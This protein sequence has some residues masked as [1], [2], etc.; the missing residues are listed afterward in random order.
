MQKKP[1]WLQK[2]LPSPSTTLSGLHNQLL[3]IPGPDLAPGQKS[4]VVAV[5][6][7][8]VQFF[9]G[10]HPS[11]YSFQ[12]C[13]PRLPLPALDST[14]NGF[15]K[16]MGP[17]LD[18]AEMADLTKKARVRK[19]GTGLRG[20]MLTELGNFKPRCYTLSTQCQP[21]RSENQVRISSGG[22]QNWHVKTRDKLWNVFCVGT[23]S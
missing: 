11:L 15:L 22:N 18:E 7:K 14:V 20:V 1:E 13:L 6:G 17:V 12:R 19:M 5:W 3:W 4:L 9:N 21:H 8:T 16:S 10:R 2:V 23:G